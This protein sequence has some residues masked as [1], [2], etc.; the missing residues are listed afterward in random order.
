M[1]AALRT[2]VAACA[3]A[4]RHP[5]V[6]LCCWVAVTAVAL[7]VIAPAVAA[8]DHALAHHPAAARSLD[9]SLDWDFARGHPEVTVRAGGACLVIGALFAWLAGGIL[10]VVGRRRP[11]RLRDVLAE[12][13]GLWLANLRVL[14][15]TGLALLVAHG[16]LDMLS[17][18]MRED[19][20]YEVE[21]GS[22]PLP[23]AHDGVLVGLEAFDWLRGFVFLVVV[24]V[25]KMALARLAVSGRR[26][27]VLAWTAALGRALR[28]PV[29]TLVLV[30]LIAVAWLGVGHVL[31]EITVRVLEVKQR[32]WIGLA[33]GQLGIVWTQVVFVASLVAARAM[34][35]D[36]VPAP[37]PSDPGSAP[38]AISESVS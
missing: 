23:L 28:R 1:R 36:P 16:G 3:T 33:V 32:P 22:V 27:A 7:A 2:F 26:S 12:G 31:G 19:W 13:G 14:A 6:V 9:L 35:E 4:L 37:E 10:V 11:A 30:G 38:D 34:I 8:L 15:V 24:F 5:R 20:L 17:R 29:R 25:G 18:W 21:P